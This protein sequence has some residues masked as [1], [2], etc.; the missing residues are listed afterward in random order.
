MSSWALTKDPQLITSEELNLYNQ[1]QCIPQVAISDLYRLATDTINQESLDDVDRCR[2]EVWTRNA[3]T[4]AALDQEIIDRNA[5]YKRK[6]EGFHV[7]R[8]AYLSAKGV[9]EKLWWEIKGFW[10]PVKFEE[11]I[12][13][14]L[15]R[16]RE[17]H[18]ASVNIDDK[19]EEH[20]DISYF[21]KLLGL[22]AESESSAE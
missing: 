20:E 21:T 19:Y 4:L 22:L 3:Q 16:A 15:R 2:A 12:K 8:D 11:E 1:A 7:Y 14:K 18:A 10:N 13:G 5:T 9:Y 17:R 6:W